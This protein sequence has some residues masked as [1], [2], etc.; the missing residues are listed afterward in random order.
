MDKKKQK[1]VLDKINFPEHFTFGQAYTVLWW[2]LFNKKKYFYFMNK[3]N[4]GMYGPIAYKHTKEL[5]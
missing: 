4:D 1:E 3:V 2:S 5:E